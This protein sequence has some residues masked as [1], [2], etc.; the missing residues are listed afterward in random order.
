[1]K[2]LTQACTIAAMLAF[3]LGTEWMNA[4][5]GLNPMIAF[6]LATA[7]AIAPHAIKR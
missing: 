4:G 1:M 6:P 2:L 7:L 3:H 5:Y